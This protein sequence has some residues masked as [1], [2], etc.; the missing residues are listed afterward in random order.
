M[1]R[2]GDWWLFCDDHRFQPLV[3]LTFLFT[4]VASVASI[5][6]GFFTRKAE[7]PPQNPPTVAQAERPPT[8]RDLFKS[9]F[10]NVLKLFTD[11][12]CEIQWNNGEEYGFV[13]QLYLD[14]GAKSEFVRYYLP[15]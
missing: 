12:S 9:D 11:S 14:F 7:T 2:L 3:W 8:L 1:G 13:C 4:V 15:T 6:S 10:S 5:Y